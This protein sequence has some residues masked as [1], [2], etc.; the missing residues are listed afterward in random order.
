MGHHCLRVH[1]C[2]G[3]WLFWRRAGGF[4]YR[5]GLGTWPEWLERFLLKNGVTEIVL[6]GEQRDHHKAAVALAKKHNMHVTVTE[7]GYLRPDW[8]TFERDGM[9]GNTCFT[10]DPDEIAQIA[11]GLPEP[12][13]EVRYPDSFF[14][15]AV[16]GL[17]ADVGTWVFGFLY[18]GYRCHLLM[19]PLALYICTGLRKWKA[20]RNSEQANSRV[21][22]LA[23]AAERSP[24]FMFPMQIEAD[25]QVRAYSKYT[26]LESALR[27][28]IGS[29]ALHAPT[30]RR[31]II[32]VHPMDP[33]VRP[34][35]RIVARIAS[36]YKAEARVELIDGGSF[37]EL[38]TRS[39]GVVTIN[40]TCGVE[41][42]MTGVPV[43]TL[44]ESLY[45]IP[46]LTFQ[47]ALDHFWSKAEPPKTPLRQQYIS[48]IAACIQIKG[49][50][51]S[52]EGLKALV[53]D[54]AIRLDKGMVN[55]PLMKQQV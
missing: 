51:F 15:L 43:K 3:D 34:W 52:A 31:L 32:K 42:I 22:A 14:Q 29:F 23:D 7:W 28:V 1:L 47:G 45:D 18:P 35:K 21:K 38:A 20:A 37:G 5:G 9:S 10:K 55:F 6:L 40:S 19:N 39:S 54:A 53:E 50:F 44:G 24:Y 11:E 8:I 25:F 17:V 2:F 16:N 33:G 46:G 27:D 30:S 49:G 26:G 36:E 13:F 4:H 48:A 12:D 41:A